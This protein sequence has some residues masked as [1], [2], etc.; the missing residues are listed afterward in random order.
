MVQPL[1]EDWDTV[2][3]LPV[4]RTVPFWSVFGFYTPEYAIDTT[5][6]RDSSPSLPPSPKPQTTTVRQQ[7]LRLLQLVGARPDSVLELAVDLNQ[8]FE[9]T[10]FIHMPAVPAWCSCM[11]LLQR[12][13]SPA[14]TAVTASAPHN[15]LLVQ[16]AHQLHDRVKWWTAELRRVEKLNRS[17]EETRSLSD[18][19]F[20]VRVDLSGWGV[21]D[22]VGVFHVHPHEDTRAPALMIRVLARKPRVWKV[23]KRPQSS[24]TCSPPP[25][26]AYPFAAPPPFVV[27][28]FV[29]AI[30]RASLRPPTQQKT[31]SEMAQEILNSP[32]KPGPLLPRAQQLSESES[33]SENFVSPHS[34]RVP[35]YGTTG[36]GSKDS[37]LCSPTFA[38]R[39]PPSSAALRSASRDCSPTHLPAPQHASPTVSPR[40]R[41]LQKELE[42]LA[43]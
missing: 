34:H 11:G 6:L 1:E 43:V 27:Q 5:D 28:S 22:S 42:P 35:T 16:Q 15:E 2:L 24:P 32:T 41:F 14:R 12:S 9:R 20:K 31:F 10:A 37:S 30:S 38:S 13:A 39:P 8:T 4:T 23:S 18:L 21:R 40:L 36:G 17:S 19:G 33:A 7:A 29:P 3:V 25:S 26:I